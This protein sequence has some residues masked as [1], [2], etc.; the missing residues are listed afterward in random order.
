MPEFYSQ[1]DVA[2][3]NNIGFYGLA[4]DSYCIMGKMVRRR[5]IIEKT[6]RTDAG[7][8][9][10]I[11][12]DLVKLFLAGNS[13]MLFI[14]DFLFDSDKKSIA[15]AVGNRAEIVEIE[16]EK[17]LGNMILAND[18]G[19]VISPMIKHLKKNIERVSGLNAE[20]STIANINII[21]SA[22]LCTNKGCLLHPQVTN[23]EMKAI[24]KV[25]A[26]KAD[27]GT[28]SFGS[29]YPGSGIIANSSGFVA[30]SASSG[31]EL[32][33]IAEALGFVE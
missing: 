4:T 22:A 25:L 11:G 13:S 7:E 29:P 31:P 21:G 20:I 6:L 27:I 18:N 9:T 19:I 24:E 28:V 5:E 23:S 12:L 30:S 3:D 14:P 2:G 8:A 26:V 1:T 16:T 15:E 10:I 32:G 17:A 33:R